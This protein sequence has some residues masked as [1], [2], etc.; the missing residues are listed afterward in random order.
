MIAQQYLF[1]PHC[2]LVPA[3]VPVHL[4]ITSADAVHSLTFNG[5][6]YAVKVLPGTISEAQLQF[7]RPGEYKMPCR[8]FCGAGHYAMRSEL[9]VVPREQFPA[10]RP[11]KGGPVRRNRRRSDRT[12]T[13][14]QSLVAGSLLLL[15]SDNPPDRIPS[16]V[17]WTPGDDSGGLARRCFSG[18][19]PRQAL[20]SLPRC[21]RLQ[22]R[23]FNPQPGRHGQ[24]G[25]L[26]T[27][28][29]FPNS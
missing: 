28:G 7:P 13:G 19:A 16:Y 20:R 6:D 18:N 21:G 26:E 3:G 24:T 2:I 8:E 17:A 12:L 9:K 4:R 27:T 11:E 1:V 29:R 25:N 5:T 22:R 23:R 15:A 14:R 10:L